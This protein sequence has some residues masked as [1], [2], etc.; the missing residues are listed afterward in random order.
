VT[1]DEYGLSLKGNCGG[2]KTVRA[3]RTE[4]EKR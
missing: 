4:E 1:N 2:S 3:I